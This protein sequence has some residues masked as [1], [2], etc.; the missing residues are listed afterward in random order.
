MAFWVYMLK[1]VDGS[2]YTGHTD[3][4]EVRIGQHEAG[5]ITGCYTHSRR[6]VTLVFSQ[7]CAT[8]E[9]ALAAERQIKGWSRAKKEVMIAGKW[10]EVSRL[11]RSGNI[12]Q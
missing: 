11:A 8:R 2:Y 9:E 7:P 12:G 4:L 6:P 10:D 1:C 5:A 3:S